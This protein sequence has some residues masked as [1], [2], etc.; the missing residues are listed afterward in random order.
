MIIFQLFCAY[1]L[2][3]TVF[4]MRFSFPFLNHTVSVCHPALCKGYD[5]ELRGQEKKIIMKTIAFMNKQ[6]D[7]SKPTQYRISD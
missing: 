3:M 6:T 4:S 2:Q 7:K 5:Y 1:C